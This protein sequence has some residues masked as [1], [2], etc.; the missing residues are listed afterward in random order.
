M[1]HNVLPF[2]GRSAFLPPFQPSINPSPLF[3]LESLIMD[4][5]H[6]SYAQM[7]H[8]T[9]GC[10]KA[11]RAR[12]VAMYLAHVGL[13]FSLSALARYFGRDRTTIAHACR[14]IEDARDERSFDA[15]L[16]ALE[17][18]VIDLTQTRLQA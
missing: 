2:S 12:Q 3:K 4:E 10:A 17:Q 8:A 6:I 7:R 14:V 11:A 16:D 9:R 15:L 18:R 1:C 5:F 13:Q